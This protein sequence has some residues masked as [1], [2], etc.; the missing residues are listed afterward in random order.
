MSCSSAQDYEAHG[1]HSCLCYG[2][3]PFCVPGFLCH[4]MIRDPPPSDSPP[5]DE[6]RRVVTATDPPR[7]AGRRCEVDGGAPTRRPS[8]VLRRAGGP[9]EQGAASRTRDDVS[10]LRLA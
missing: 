7:R 6:P 9:R 10:V 4:M 2:T 5:P 8:V 3:L 1:S